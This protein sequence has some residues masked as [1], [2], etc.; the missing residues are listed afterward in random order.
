MKPIKT[1]ALS[2]YM[3]LLLGVSGCSEQHLDAEGYGPVKTGMT[4][5]QASTALGETL[6]PNQPLHEDEIYCHYVY[7]DGDPEQIGF[8][9]EG[10]IITRMD[11]YQIN[12]ST[13]T[14]IK[15]GDSEKKVYA[16]Y[17]GRILETAHPYIGEE[18]KYLIVSTIKGHKI[19]FETKRG[20]I[21]SFRTGKLPSVA[22]IEGCM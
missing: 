15:I 4:V 20:V 18:G 14:G 19:I 22:Y 10:D 11:V 13:D 1:V 2:S 16:A 5:V 7:P 3:L 17:K 6:K 12:Y 8:M 21:T 9:V